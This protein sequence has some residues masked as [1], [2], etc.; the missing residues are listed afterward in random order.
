MSKKQ[1]IDGLFC[2][3]FPIIDR[4]SP[5]QYR[6]SLDQLIECESAVRLTN[7]DVEARAWLLGGLTRLMLDYYQSQFSHAATIAELVEAVFRFSQ[8]PSCSETQAGVCRALE[9]AGQP[10]K[11]WSGLCMPGFEV[12][13]PENYPADFAGNAIMWAGNAV[14]ASLRE[15]RDVMLL[16]SV[17]DAVECIARMMGEREP[18]DEDVSFWDSGKRHLHK[19]IDNWIDAGFPFVS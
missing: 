15:Y 3:L 2:E 12:P 10:L 5:L 11:S 13:E 6:D 14:A 18:L 17:H 9:E 7:H 8:S 1:R 19:S 16:Y 4:L